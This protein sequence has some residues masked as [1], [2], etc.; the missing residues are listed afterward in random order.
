[1]AKY[2]R[3]QII[4]ALLI[5]ARHAE[6]QGDSVESKN[7]LEQAISIA[8]YKNEPSNAA[9]AG[10]LIRLADS[11]AER[12]LYSEAEQFYEDAIAILESVLSC[13]H[14]SVAI[15]YR[16]LSEILKS[17][18]RQ[19]EANNMIRHCQPILDRFFQFAKSVN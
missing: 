1:M 19:A 6:E 16:N 18:G 2:G 7:L 15:A 17:Q 4:N 10:A 14:A 12:T 9:Y 11:C 5:G 8:R 3:A 13:D